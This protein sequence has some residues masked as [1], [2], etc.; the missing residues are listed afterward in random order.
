MS[1]SYKKTPIC[2]ITSAESEKQ[3]KRIAN[4]RF[5]RNARQLVKIGKEPPFNI[6]VV[7][8][9][10]SF[11]KDGKQYFSAMKYPYLLRK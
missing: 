2:G 8:N 5:R 7:S 10:Y 6:R 4:R 11:D 1:R 9:V 3:D